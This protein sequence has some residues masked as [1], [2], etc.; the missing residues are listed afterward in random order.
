MRSIPLPRYHWLCVH[1]SYTLV[2]N[3][4]IIIGV[5]YN[6]LLFSGGG[7][8]SADSSISAPVINRARALA[9]SSSSSIVCVYRCIYY[10]LDVSHTKGDIFFLLRRVDDLK[11]LY[12]RRLRQYNN[13][14]QCDIIYKART[15]PTTV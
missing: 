1:F 14:I 8:L 5:S 10:L 15:N 4:N 2:G 3:N 9:G 11:G 12:S 6:Y 7:D 13:N